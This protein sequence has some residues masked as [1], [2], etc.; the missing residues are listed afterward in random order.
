[1]KKTKV[2]YDVEC[3]RNF[4]YA[5][6]E[7]PKQIYQVRLF[8]DEL[9][10]G[11]R[12][13]VKSIM[14]K[15]LLIGF[16]IKAYDNIM[17]AAFIAGYTNDQLKNLSDQLI[18]TRAHW[19]VMDNHP[20]VKIPAY[21]EFVDL[22][23][24]TPLMASLKTYACRI[25]T[26]TLQD[27]PLHP[28]TI[29]TQEESLELAKYCGNDIQM[30]AD[31]YQTCL[32]DLRLRRDMTHE[33][34]MDFRSMS[35]PQ[36]AEAVLR[37]QLRDKGVQVERRRDKVKPFKYK[38]PKWI[39]FQ[40]KE[41]KTIKQA[42]KQAKFTVNKNGYAE[43]PESLDQVIEFAGGKYKMGI[44]GL[45]SQEKHQAVYGDDGYLGEWDV[46]SMYPSI[47]LGQGLYP[48]HIGPEFCDVYREI[49]DTR[50]AAKKAGDKV[51]SESLKLVLNSSFGKFGSQY[52]FLYSPEL[53]IQTTITGQL[54]LLMLIEMFH[55]EGIQTY[56]A[57]TDGVVVRMPYQHQG[58][59]VFRWQKRTGMQLEWTE[60][61]AI[62]SESVNNYIALAGEDLK[63]KGSYAPPGIGKGYMAPIVITALA[64]FLKEQVPLR[65]TIER[66]DDVREF[67]TMR[68]IHDGGVWRGQDLGRVARWY[69]STDGEPIRY[70][71]N[72]NK[73]AGSDGAVPMMTLADEIPG[74]L[75]H[76]WYV[77]RAEKLLPK[78]G[79]K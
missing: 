63:L 24:V 33:Y 28:D 20:K 4:F 59:T 51:T 60:Y 19:E 34:G 62:Y 11:S 6:F 77:A 26:K 52:S 5:R 37:Q 50:M 7:S 70:R 64:A 46:G 35:G 2:F 41:L 66:C 72:G 48:E 39:Q 61:D 43:L 38:M 25:H 29:V 9:T 67:L 13:A 16:N 56:S 10:D 57:N 3:Y 68:G 55:L 1:M 40:T 65:D 18:N 17:L 74:D 49:Y 22:V 8:N 14:Q 21:T 58:D 44:G 71:S 36:I 30:T 76:D 54:S 42:V 32:P 53:L 78:L 15:H 79:V 73:V 23:G 45:H 75:D 31:I 12:K 47:I 69:V 27:L